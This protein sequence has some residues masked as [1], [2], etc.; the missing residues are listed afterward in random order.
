MK[1]TTKFLILALIFGL[2]YA[3]NAQNVFA[4][5]SLTSVSVDLLGDDEI[6]LFKQSFEN[7]NVS[8]AEALNQLKAKGMKEDE[9]RKLKSRLNA[10]EVEDPQEKL[11]MLSLKLLQMQ[12]SL[13]RAKRSSAE[14]SAL[15]RLYYLDSNVFGAE[16]FRNERMDFAPN[17]SIATPPSYRIGPGDYL[18]VTVY[19]YQEFNRTLLVEPTGSI[20]VPYVG[21]VNLSGLTMKEAR[22]KLYQI[23]SNNGYQTL[24][25]STSELALNLK[26][27]RGIDVTVVGAKVP[28][29][30]TVP[31]V[32]SPYHVLHLAAGPAAKGSYRDIK[33]LRNGKVVNTID[34]YELLVSGNKHDDIRLEDGDVIFIPTYAARVT[35]GGEFRRVYSYEILPGESLS[36]V[37]EWSGGFTEQAYKDKIYVERVGAVSFYADVVSKE[38]FSTYALQGGDF[39]VADTLRDIVRNRVAIAGGVQFPGHYAVMDGLTAQKLIDLAGGPREG[40]LLS[41]LTIS[42]K[43]IDGKRSYRSISGSAIGLE[44]LGEGDSVLVPTEE[45]FRKEFDVTVRGEVML[46]G[47]LSYGPGL[48]LYDVIMLAGGFTGDADTTN[49]EVARLNSQKTS[50]RRSEVRTVSLKEAKAFELQAGDAVSVRYSRDR[51]TTASVEFIGEVE[52]AGAYGLLEPFEDLSSV[53]KRSKGLTPYADPNGVFLVRQSSMV[54]GDTA[55]DGSSFNVVKG[56]AF[57]QDT[58]ALSL[59]SVYGRRRFYLQD[60]D[61]IHVLSR[62]TTVRLAGAVF[63]PSIVSHSGSYQFLSY[64]SQAGG[65]TEVGDPRKAYVIYPNGAAKRTR[66]YVLWVNRPKV[67]PG[68]TVVVPEKAIKTSRTSPAEVAAIG[69]ILASMTTLIVTLITLL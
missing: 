25:N 16:L 63:Q 42:Q 41:R 10:S 30:Y 23:F 60:G 6:F 36:K 15:E 22:A 13:S 69:G 44:I 8:P 11:Q 40:A 67:V 38:Q 57:R 47:A 5:K 62:Q 24:K 50:L 14:L 46:P 66:N 68:S 52:I 34:L 65:H 61:Q 18:D 27:V 56:E 29:R 64:I 12:D 35:L 19:G 32:A 9:L 55:L 4:R 48:T 20:N 43:S 1:S 21:V 3:G 28:G 31:G 51:V 45:M 39:L 26:V 37:L 49:F 53:L 33:L 58:I 54:L 59:A 7:K 2:S 17:V